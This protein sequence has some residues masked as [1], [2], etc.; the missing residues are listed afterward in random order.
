VYLV[1]ASSHSNSGFIATTKTQLRAAIKH[2]IEAAKGFVKSV[3][4][5]PPEIAELVLRASLQAHADEQVNNSFVFGNFGQ[6]QAADTTRDIAEAQRK[7]GDEFEVPK[8]ILG[9]P[10]QEGGEKV[11]LSVQLLLAGA[12]LLKVAPKLA[13]NAVTPTVRATNGVRIVGTSGRVA[14]RPNEA[15]FWSGRTNGIGGQEVAAELAAQKEGTTLEM[16]IEKNKIEMPPWDPNDPAA[17]KAWEDISAEYA[18]GASGRV[19]AIIGQSLRP[20]NVW[21]TKE[22]PRLLQ[23][24]NVTEIVTIDPVSHVEKTIFKR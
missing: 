24:P 11:G 13:K 4:N 23:N 12:G 22:L 1:Q 10:A 14:T 6:R 17:I 8:F 16:L 15:F 2:P 21:E 9:N 5:G 19:R 3:A 7:I 20:G 18:T